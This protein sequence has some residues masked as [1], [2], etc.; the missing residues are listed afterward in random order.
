MRQTA[1]KIDNI[2]NGEPILRWAGSKKTVL[3]KLRPY[4]PESY[5]KYIELFSGSACLFFKANP[6]QAVLADTNADLINFYRVFSQN[7]EKIYKIFLS[8]PR[9]STAY[10][11][12]RE[13]IKTE[14][15]PDK[16]AALFLYLNRNC[17]NGI[18]RTNS[19]GHFN[20]P[21]SADRIAAYPAKNV[22]LTTAEVLKKAQVLCG[23]FEEI[24]RAQVEKND[25]VY[26]DPPYYV[27][28]VRVF[29]EY[30]NKPFTIEDFDRLSDLL[31]FIDK[32]K[33]MFMLSYPDCILS[34]RIAQRWKSS[35]ILVKRI[36]GGTS[37]SRKGKYELIIR[38]Y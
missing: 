20:V 32:K 36:V 33:A 38:N 34:R 16:R 8:Y 4:L 24:C 30:S 37:D 28:N 15:N 2:K 21:F 11:R 35:R 1:I 31:D 27:P 17:F 29:K 23:D 5:N 6:S 14:S 9:T 3:S 26:L 13:S 25:F 12:A 7:P 10:Y 19:K 18:H 22:F